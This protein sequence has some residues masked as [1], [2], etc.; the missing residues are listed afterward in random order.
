[1]S[2][3]TPMGRNEER[4]PVVVVGESLNCLGTV[5]SLSGAGIEIHVA[6]TT[7]WCAPSLS[8][9][10]H[11]T[12]FS[13]L[14][15]RGL[16]D[17]LMALSQRLGRRAVLM[18]GGDRQ[19]DVVNDHRD[20]LAPFYH[21]TLPSA[22]QVRMLANK[23]SFQRF[24]QAH[25]LPVP[26]TA[27]VSGP[28]DLAALRELDLPLVLKPADK[29]KVL[30]GRAERAVRVDSAAQAE[31]VALRML[32]AAG[33]I[34]AQ[35]WIEGGDADIYFALF[36]CDRDSR[37]VAMFCGRK[38]VCDPPDVGSTGICVEAGEFSDA[39]ACEAERFVRAAGYQGIGGV[40]FKRD[41][42]TGCF[43]IVEPTIGRTDWQEEIATQCGVNLPLQAYLVDCGLPATPAL[44]ATAPQAWS[45]SLFYRRPRETL[46][47]GAHIHDGY[48]RLADPLPGLHHYLVEEL[49]RRGVRRIARLLHSAAPQPADAPVV[50]DSRP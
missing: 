48:L 5:R 8:R 16:I 15:G 26:R 34:V 28:E 14:D 19:V 45:A 30:C 42:R 50:R 4:V 36:V 22:E 47:A 40:E 13:D 10:A 35:E 6:A 37:V 21:F 11:F 49:G 7:R 39:I 24:A 25:G 43:V 31:A 12:R 1:M 17:G 33:C 32:A 29:L 46:P 27:I 20:E 38:L 44:P 9:F 18:L 2:V 23:A 3:M 41:R